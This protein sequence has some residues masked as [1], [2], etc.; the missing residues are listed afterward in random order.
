MEENAEVAQE[1]KSK[2]ETIE[3]LKSKAIAEF[4]PERLKSKEGDENGQETKD[5]KEENAA[6]LLDKKTPEGD[7]PP[8]P[9]L[10]SKIASLAKKERELRKRESRLKEVT[11]KLTAYESALANAKTNP[12]QLLEMANLNTE[13]YAKFLL[14]NEDEDPKEKSFRMLGDEV[15][16][17]REKVE[18]DRKEKEEAQM[19]AAEVMFRSNLKDFAGENQ[20]RFPTVMAE[21]GG[22]DLAFEIVKAYYDQTGDLPRKAETREIDFDLVLGKAEDHLRAQALK[23]LDRYRNIPH[24]RDM[25]GS[26]EPEKQ[27]K[28]VTPAA[29]QVRTL[30]NTPPVST[31]KPE[32]PTGK[33]SKDEELKWAASLIKYVG[34]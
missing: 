8:L 30:T 5:K 31:P 29:G 13:D 10:A 22:I 23:R 7:K 2:E 27:K 32:R 11:D 4:L 33:M 14:N 34:E 26:K 21:D 25:F 3:D 19:R 9:D 16:A 17:L 24:F 6:Q 20:D 28:E 1:Q 12:K 18:Q 15:R